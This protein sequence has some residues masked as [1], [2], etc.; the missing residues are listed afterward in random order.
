M[1]KCHIH[2]PQTFVGNASLWMNDEPDWMVYVC[3]E[4][5]QCVC[6]VLHVIIL[7]QIAMYI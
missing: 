1:W 5:I 6:I 7:C 2:M 4:T 3:T